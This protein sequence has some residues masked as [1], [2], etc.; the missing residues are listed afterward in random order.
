[1]VDLP[2]NVTIGPAAVLALVLQALHLVI[3][4]TA[5]DPDGDGQSGA[6]FSVA[7]TVS[8]AVQVAGGVFTATV[9]GIGAAYQIGRVAAG[10]GAGAGTTGTATGTTGT[11][12]G[13]TGTATGSTGAGTGADRG[14]GTTPAAGHWQPGLRSSA[15]PPGWAWSSRPDQSPVAASSGTTPPLASTRAR[16]S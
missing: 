16:C 7:L 2:V 4:V 8:A 12:T 13:T 6:V 15:R 5:A 11:A 3:A 1:M 9:A 14:T 10:S